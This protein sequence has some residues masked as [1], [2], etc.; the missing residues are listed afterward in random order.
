ME[1][2]KKKEEGKMTN[3][4][5]RI[6]E[7]IK[8]ALETK[9]AYHKEKYHSNKE[10]KNFEVAPLEGTDLIEVLFTTNYTDGN[11]LTALHGQLFIGKRGGLNGQVRTFSNV[12]KIHSGGEFHKIT[13][14]I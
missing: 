9:I 12:S 10:I 8:E 1:F 14:W 11:C 3:K 5:E 6:V 13:M 4:Q 7:K 2:I